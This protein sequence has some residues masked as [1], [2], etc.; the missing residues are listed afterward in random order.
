MPVRI[1]KQ[2]S[3]ARASAARTGTPEEPPR[4]AHR[5]SMRKTASG[6]SNAAAA[7]RPQSSFTYI[8]PLLSVGSRHMKSTAIPPPHLAAQEERERRVKQEGG[9]YSLGSRS[10]P[11]MAL[12][13]MS[14]Q[15]RVGQS[16]R[17]AVVG[18]PA[19]GARAV[20]GDAFPDARVHVGRRGKLVYGSS[21]SESEQEV[22]LV[23]SD[24][25]EAAVP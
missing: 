9:D 10:A 7:K 16:P 11:R 3:A 21:G 19:T 4:D 8:T 15:R 6:P 25:D 24:S 2:T 18:G 5:H 22:L 1:A 13:S 12:T 14:V 23:S 20:G 17:K